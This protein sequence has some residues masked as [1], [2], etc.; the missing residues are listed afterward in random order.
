MK[1]VILSIVSCLFVL[2]VQAQ[3]SKV[4]DDKLDKLVLASNLTGAEMISLEM[5]QELNL[6][7]EQYKQIE[8]LNK[9]R[10]EKLME[11]EATYAHSPS[12]RTR[13]F[14][15]VHLQNDKALTGVLSEQQLKQY[16]ELE[17]RQNVRYISTNDEGK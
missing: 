6:T 16:L 9:Q 17:G 14:R 12:E 13:K 8:L 5:K 2:G 10:Y 15:D 7:E 4:T 11:V 1:K 3:S